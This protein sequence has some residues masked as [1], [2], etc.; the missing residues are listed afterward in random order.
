MTDV[1]GALVSL[2]GL[3]DLKLNLNISGVRRAAN[4]GGSDVVP[5]ALA[6]LKSL[7]FLQM[8]R[9]DSCQLEAGC[10]ELPNLLSL[11]FQNCEFEDVEELPGISALQS[12]TCIE[13]LSGHGPRFFNAQLAQLP[14]LER[15]VFRFSSDKVLSML[16]ADMGSLSSA[17]LYLDVTGQCSPGFHLP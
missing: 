2:T 16:P 11:R 5:A 14:G 17:L 8:C 9:L 3:A 1:V 7:Q 15:V 12:L 10:F 4:M 6:Q 13:F